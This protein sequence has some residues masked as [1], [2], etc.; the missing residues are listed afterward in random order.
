MKKYLSFSVCIIA[1]LLVTISCKKTQDYNAGNIPV[2]PYDPGTKI[3]TPVAGTVVD[4]NGL[5]LSDVSITIGTTLVSTDAN[6]RFI[7]PKAYL[8]KK[9]GLVMA[10]KEGY[11]GGSRTIYPKENVINNVTIQLIKKGQS[12]SFSSANGGTVNPANGGSITFP[13]NAVVTKQGGTYTGAVKVFA[14]FLDP[15]RKGA[16]D[17]M[18]GSLRGITTDNNEQSLTSYGMMAVELAGSNGEP[19][20]LAA[21][22]TANLSFP[23][24]SSLT[25]AAPASIPLWYFNETTGLWAQQGTATKVGNNYVGDVAHFTWWNC[26]YGGGPITYTVKFVDQNGNPINNQHVYM[27]PSDSS[28]GGGHGY[29]ASDG[30]LT[31][32]IPMNTPITI[33]MWLHTGCGETL[34]YTGHAGPFTDSANGGTIV[35]NMPTFNNISPINFTGTIVDCNNKPFTAGYASITLGGQSYYAYVLNGILNATLYN[36]TGTTYPTATLHVYEFTGSQTNIN[37]ATINNVTAGNYSF[38]QISVC[39]ALSTIHYTINL[40]DQN[41][42]GLYGNCNFTSGGSQTITG[43]F[44]SA[45]VTYTIPANT[46]ITRTITTY[47]NCGRSITDTLVIGPFNTDFNAGNVTI[48]LPQ[49]NTVYITGTAVDCNGNPITKGAAMLNSPSDSLNK[50]IANISNGIFSIPIVNCMGTTLTYSL[51]V[52]DSIN[53]QQNA[54]P[55]TVTINNSD[56]VLGQVSA[57]GL[58]TNE[59]FNYTFNGNAASFNYFNSNTYNGGYTY[60]YGSDQSGSNISFNT[61]KSTLGSLPLSYLSMSKSGTNYTIISGTN[62]YTEYGAVS[63]FI[64]GTFTATVAIDTLPGR[65]TYPV[66]GT[67][68]IRRA[69]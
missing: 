29:T 51:V 49:Q 33:T 5:G 28:R 59:F 34:V 21:G 56:V 23:I 55:I 41:G 50:N 16:Y 65:P 30:S 47:N 53:K 69:N 36:C 22:K 39:G 4:E 8:Y 26:D 13:A 2:V 19:L 12:G 46:V 67:Y 62:N 37:T 25:A 68:R 17:K 11:F 3:T 15:T 9:A 1:M 14:Y 27:L 57:C 64:A 63:Q 10:T 45:P 38:G 60:I 44:N 7:I 18:P 31:G 52:I 43:W 24:A 48:N 20:Q 32:N 42:Q 58:S 61:T 66:T 40:V 35:V 6:G 54:N